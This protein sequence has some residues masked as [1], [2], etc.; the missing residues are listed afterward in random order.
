MRIGVYRSADGR[1]ELVGRRTAAGWRVLDVLAPPA[2]DGDRD[3]RWVD[4]GLESVAE[5]KALG[6]DY[7]ARAREAR[8][9]QMRPSPASLK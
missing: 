3:E 5:V 6:A 4:E 8:E 2:D 7:L 9:P 1:R